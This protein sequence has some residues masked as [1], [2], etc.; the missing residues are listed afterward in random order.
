MSTDLLT[1]LH[2][3]G[4]EVVDLLA[5]HDSADMYRRLGFTEPRSTALRHLPS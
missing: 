4:V 2:A 5:S 1:W 3:A